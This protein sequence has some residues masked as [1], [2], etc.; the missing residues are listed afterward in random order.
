MAWNS[1][2]LLVRSFVFL[3]CSQINSWEYPGKQGIGCNVV[4]AN[5]SANLVSF[6]Q[7]LRRQDGAQSLI[8]SAA[9]ATTP[10]VG[11]DGTPLSDV[12]GF[13]DV[14]DY[15]GS[16]GPTSIQLTLCMTMSRRGYELRYLGTLG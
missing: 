1:S 12:S 14:L 15:I 16:L 3:S 13:A 10:F 2:A 6:L 9:V 4:S 7:T 5:D 11:S 8:L